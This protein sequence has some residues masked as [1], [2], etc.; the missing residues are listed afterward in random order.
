MRCGLSVEV[1]DGA[2]TRIRPGDFPTRRSRHL[3]ESAGHTGDGLSS[4]SAEVSAESERENGAKTNG[5]ACHG[6]KPLMRLRSSTG[7]D[8]S[9]RYGPGAVAWMVSVMP[10]LAGG[11][12]SRLASLT[13]G[14]VVDWW[15]CG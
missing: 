6:M 10:N 2:I 11:G 3:S 12:Y 9:R 13:K 5:S 7:Q 15:G 8:I 1:E 14:T 4:R